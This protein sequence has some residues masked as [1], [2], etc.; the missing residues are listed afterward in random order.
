M[1]CDQ[2]PPLIAAVTSG[3]PISPLPSFMIKAYRAWCKKISNCPNR[4]YCT[5]PEDLVPLLGEGG[6]A[7]TTRRRPSGRVRTGRPMPGEDIKTTH[8]EDARHWMSI[9][10][11]LLE[12]K[13]G[14][15]ERV[16]RDIARLP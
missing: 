6:M 13:R 10:A 15:L 11:D 2:S 4:R 16:R 5:G 7:T 12:F 3:R 14:I 8:W 1:R 9:Y